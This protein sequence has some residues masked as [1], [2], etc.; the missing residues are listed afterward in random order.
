MKVDISV[1]M[2]TYNERLDELRESVYS[3][4]NQDCK[5]FEFLIVIDNPKNNEIIE[6][7]KNIRDNDNRIKLIINSENIGLANSLNKAINIS[8]GEYIVRMDADDISKRNRLTMQYDFMEKNKDIGILGTNR[9]DIDENGNIIK[10]Y[11]T[12]LNGTKLLNAIEYGSVLCHPTVMIRKTV[13]NKIGLY[14]NFES[15]Q[16]YDLWLRAVNLDIPIY[17]LSTILLKYRIRSNS[18]SSSNPLKQFLYA[19]YGR[20]LY[21]ERKKNSIDSFSEENKALFLKERGLFD[22]RKR[23]KFN[24][25]FWDVQDKLKKLK[26][27]RKISYY[28]EIGSCLILNKELRKWFYI[29]FMFKVKSQ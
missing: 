26:T 29:S 20:S 9:V 19:E 12:V 6:W 27:K 25:Q 21:K 28:I 4:L 17:N 1:I 10:E 23:A 15:A 13:F 7:L 3:I 24:K 5:N 2:S 18:I 11:Q 14:R 16:D 22:F 8:H